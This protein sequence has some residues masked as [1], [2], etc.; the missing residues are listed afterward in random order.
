M[1]T[2]NRVISTYSKFYAH[3]IFMIRSS[4]QRVVLFFWSFCSGHFAFLLRLRV[5][6]RPQLFRI[7]HRHCRT[8]GVGLR[9][10]QVNGNLVHIGRKAFFGELYE[11]CVRQ[12]L[13]VGI[14][15]LMWLSVAN[16]HD[17]ASDESDEADSHSGG[18]G[19]SE[20]C[21]H[22]CRTIMVCAQLLWLCGFGCGGTWQE[23]F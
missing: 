19:G 22:L 1:H 15:V 3:K 16:V 12:C 11:T 23:P 7:E 4:F 14:V 18:D 2:Q 8:R 10:R 6:L 13:L 20:Q 17:D 9:G 5:F 21:F